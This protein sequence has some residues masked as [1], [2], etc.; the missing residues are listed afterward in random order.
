[1]I[2]IGESKITSTK[3]ET[4]IFKGILDKLQLPHILDG[5][6]FHNTLFDLHWIKT[7]HNTKVWKVEKDGS[8]SLT[9]RFGHN[10]R[11][12]YRKLEIKSVLEF[13]FVDL[14]ILKK[15]ELKILDDLLFKVENKP[16]ALKRKG[17]I[18]NLSE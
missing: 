3:Q 13:L 15:E 11:F 8:L 1:M 4:K 10:G 16:D 5:I 9:N 2:K 18:D 12:T 6:S 7:V 14:S 17:Q